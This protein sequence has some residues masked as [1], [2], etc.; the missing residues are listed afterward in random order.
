MAVNQKRSLP[1]PDFTF[2]NN[3]FSDFFGRLF[4]RILQPFIS[5]IA[6]DLFTFVCF[7]L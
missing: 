7:E 4:K 2:Q 6:G 5:K 3:D 1:V